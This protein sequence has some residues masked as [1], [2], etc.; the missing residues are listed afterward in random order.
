MVR[1]NA[2]G[3]FDTLVVT[4]NYE[5]QRPAARPT[6]FDLNSD[7]AA[8]ALLLSGCIDDYESCT[9]HWIASEG[10]L[11]VLENADRSGP[12]RFSAVMSDAVLIEVEPDFEFG[13]PVVNGGM[14]T[15]DNVEMN[16]ITEAL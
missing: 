9:Q 10:V 16:V 4:R 7:Y 14:W 1:Q 5:I 15:I 13:T 12:G 11:T 2:D 3:T 6:D 8:Y